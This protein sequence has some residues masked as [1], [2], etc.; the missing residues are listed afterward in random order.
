MKLV[1]YEPYQI[2]AI[3]YMLEKGGAVETREIYNHV[4]GELGI[5]ISRASV[6]H[7]LNDMAEESF[8]EKAFKTGK[9][10]IRGVY[11]MKVDRK[12]FEGRVLTGIVEELM[13]L[14]PRNEALK[15]CVDWLK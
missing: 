5:N 7:F 15:R 11:R 1:A 2:A 3:N 10:G 14:F 8:L 13:E 6:I 9:G 12:G 4:A